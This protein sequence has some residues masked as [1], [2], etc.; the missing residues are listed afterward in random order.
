[1]LVIVEGRV[2]LELGS[3]QIE[4]QKPKMTKLTVTTMSRCA[5]TAAAAAAL[6]A[7]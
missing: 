3:D 2:K 1:M 5:A 6:G 7:V 4:I